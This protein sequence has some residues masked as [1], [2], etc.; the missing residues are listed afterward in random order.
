MGEESSNGKSTEFSLVTVVCPD[1][2]LYVQYSFDK[3]CFKNH[4]LPVM[5]L[6]VTCIKFQHKAVV[7]K[8]RPKSCSDSGPSTRPVD[9]VPAKD[10]LP[11][12]IANSCVHVVV[13]EDL[14]IMLVTKQV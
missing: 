1:L 11:I 13:V 7:R 3:S 4:K 9:C 2:I 5:T 14:N 8:A 12:A 6:P 10:L